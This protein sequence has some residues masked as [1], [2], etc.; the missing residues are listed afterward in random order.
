MRG[1]QRI[2]LLRHGNAEPDVRPDAARPLTVYGRSEI[3]RLVT[4]RGNDLASVSEVWVSP[5]VRARQSAEVVAPALRES[6]TWRVDVELLKPTGRVRLLLEMLESV[7]AE[8][9]LLVTHQPLVGTL[10]DELCGFE[11][12]RYRLGT[13]SC[14]SVSLPYGIGPGLGE[15]DW[16]EHP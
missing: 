14:A 13:G 4:A 7:Q 3:S 11:V 2:L 5:L 9:L 16:L 1:P 6:V 12:G 10:L 8:C 15:L